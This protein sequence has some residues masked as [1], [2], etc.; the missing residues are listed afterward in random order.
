MLL[1]LFIGATCLAS[2][3]A[4]QTTASSQYEQPFAPHHV[5]G[6]LYFVGTAGLSNYLVTTPEGHILINSDLESTVPIIRKN[7]ELLG[8]KFSDVKILLISHA[9]FDHN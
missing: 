9:H 2:L 4:A 3:A 7:I 8:F 6:N 5:A 1:K